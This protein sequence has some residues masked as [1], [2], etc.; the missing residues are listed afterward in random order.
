MKRLNL[1]QY[2]KGPFTND[3]SLEGEGQKLPILLIKRRTK[4]KKGGHKIQNMGRRPTW[5]AS[6]GHSQTLTRR[7]G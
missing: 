6:K 7:G 5:M 4:G 1:T 2:H 3:A